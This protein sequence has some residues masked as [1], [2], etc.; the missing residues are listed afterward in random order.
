MT[1]LPSLENEEI[2]R[3]HKH[4]LSSLLLPLPASRTSVHYVYASRRDA[5]CSPSA[6]PV[7]LS[8][9]LDFITASYPTCVVS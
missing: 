7:P 4:S 3:C 6:A 1:A 5:V 2:L 8:W 9:P